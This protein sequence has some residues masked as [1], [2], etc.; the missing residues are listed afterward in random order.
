MLKGKEFGA[1]IDAAIQKKL[2]TGQV[3]SRAEIARH[4]GIK[5]PSLVDWVKK[6]S[7]DKSKLPEVWRYFSDVVGPEHWGMTADEWP[8]GLAG[9]PRSAKSAAPRLEWPFPRIDESKVRSLDDRARRDLETAI[10]AVSLSLD[11]DIKKTD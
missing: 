6:G 5:P 11:L 9:A 3:R 1:A 8:S 7:I 4:F 10:L 2:D